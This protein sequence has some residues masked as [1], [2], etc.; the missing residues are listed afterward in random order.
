M[1]QADPQNWLCFNPQDICDNADNNCNGTTDENALKCGSPAHCPSAEVCGNA[2]DDDCDG[3]TDEGCPVCTPTPEV[4]D[5]C[6]NDC[7]GVA[8]DGIVPV[9]CG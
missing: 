6:D 4:C 7:D 5:G 3:Q 9:V 8:D 1:Q 2:Q